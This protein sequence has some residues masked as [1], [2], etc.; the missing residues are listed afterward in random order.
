M[1]GHLQTNKAKKALEVFDAIDSL[2]SLNLAETLE[3][4]L[5]G[6]G[7]KIPILIQVKLSEK[8]T[9]SGAAPEEVAALIESLKAFGH[10]EARGLMG[11]A[12]DLEPVEA[13]RPHFRMMRR[14]FER[15]FSGLSGAQLSM[16]MSRDFEIAVEEGA[17]HVR[18]GTSIFS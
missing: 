18:I 16:G 3:R 5:A 14:L 9:R 13:V 10:L 17:T 6:G 12:P 1:I 4:L 7:R 2:D 15:N 8:E 11:I